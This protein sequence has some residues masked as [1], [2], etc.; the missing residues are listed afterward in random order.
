MPGTRG[1]DQMYIFYYLTGSS[2]SDLEKE[3]QSWSHYVVPGLTLYFK[4]VVIKQYGI[5][6]KNRHISGTE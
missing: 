5:G 6:I 1:R 3:E 4:A 2:Q